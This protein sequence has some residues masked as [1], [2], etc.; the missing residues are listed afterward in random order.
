MENIKNND[1]LLIS[2]VL[3]KVILPYTV[4]EIKEIIDDDSNRFETSDQVIDKVFTRPLSEYKFQA[5][6][7]YNE[8]I[9]LAREC[10]EC[11]TIDTIELA[12]E[13]MGKRYL[14]PSIITA[15]R[16]IN[17][18]YVY[19]DCLE[20][21]EL[22]DFKIFKIKYELYPMVVKNKNDFIENKNIFEK[23][24]DFIKNLFKK[25]VIKE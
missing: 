1:T 8:T 3:N 12:L 23:F 5:W 13:M 14:H 6:S 9:E 2:E 16:N 11:G 7:R 21:D 15:C 19:L 20:K 22:D 4:D 10:K 25:N 17:E 24:I 18:L